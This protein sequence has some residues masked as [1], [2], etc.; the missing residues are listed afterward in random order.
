M[1]RAQR[2]ENRPECNLADEA[3]A[4]HFE[5]RAV[6]QLRQAGLRVTAPRVQVIRALSR[7]NGALTAYEI[8]AQIVAAGERVDVVTVY[9]VLQALM[10]AGLVHRLGVVDGYYACRA[11]GHQGSCEHLV[12]RECGCVEELPLIALVSKALP[13]QAAE[14]GFTCETLRVEVLGVCSHC[15]NG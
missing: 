4:Q 13:A 12:C 1:T 2:S 7:T 14:A 10:E 3:L 15:R 11:E 5:A 6:A 9:R 8:H